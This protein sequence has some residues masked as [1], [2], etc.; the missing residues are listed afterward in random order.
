MAGPIAMA[1]SIWN[2][3]IATIALA[4]FLFSV[5][6]LYVKFLVP[7]VPPFEVAFIPSVVCLLTTSTVVYGTGAPIFVKSAWVTFL[8]LLRG[9]L[10]ATSLVLYYLSLNLLP[11][12]DAVTL[13]FCSPAVLCC[14]YPSAVLLNLTPTVISA[15]LEFT[16]LGNS[17]TLGSLLGCTF[18]VAGVVLVTQPGG[19]AQED[20]GPEP[21]QRLGA[22]LAI[23]AAACNAASF[24]VVRLLSGRQSPVVITWWYNVVLMLATLVPLL[25]AYPLPPVLPNQH[26]ALLLAAISIAQFSGQLVLNRG[27]Q[28]V[29]PTKGSA[30]NVLQVLFSYMWGLTV[31]HDTLN[32]VSAAGGGCVM[33]GVVC[34][35]LGGSS[36]PKAQTEPL[37]DSVEPDSTLPVAE[38]PSVV[39]A[40]RSVFVRQSIL[41]VLENVVSEAGCDGPL[42]LP[43]QGLPLRSAASFT[44]QSMPAGLGGGD[45]ALPQQHEAQQGQSSWAVTRLLSHK[46]TSYAG[47][48][49]LPDADD[50]APARA[51]GS[52]Q[53]T[54]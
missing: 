16:L 36:A 31:L 35:A 2:S 24:I 47:Y 50:T 3:G 17:L 27:F 19:E 1:G 28:L 38:E 23:A 51:V 43:P 5:S 29:S 6:S 20:T 30:I 46:F 9:V 18:T 44:R 34:V 45:G 7:G 4:A 25:L 8:T 48:E 41:K 54:V 32:W 13:Y 21:G 15:F 11:L 49:R 26:Q 22:M 10:G 40:R 52:A 12:K 14:P 42:G 39:G 33:L 53:S 37:L